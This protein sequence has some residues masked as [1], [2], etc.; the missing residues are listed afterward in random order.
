[1]SHVIEDQAERLLALDPT[2]SF[3]VQAPAG[4]GKT[5]LL[6]QRYL[7]LLA[8]V[9]RPEEILAV[10]FTKKAANEM[11][12][13]V[14]AALRH[15]K[16]ENEPD[17]AHKKQ[18]WKLARAVLKQD[19]LNHW[20]V[21]HNP[22]Q[23]R[24]QTI[25]SFCSYLTKHLPLLSQFGATPEIAP[26]ARSLYQEAVH[27]ILSHLDQDHPWSSAIMDVLAHLDNDMDKLA[28]LLIDLLAKRDQWLPYL[29]L[30]HSDRE[31]LETQLKSVI[32][33]LINKAKKTL[34]AEQL[35][36]LYA[37]ARYAGSQ[38]KLI[39]NTNPIA[40]CD[41]DDP[42]WEGIATLLLTKEGEFRKTWTIKQGFPS[43]SSASNA[44]DKAAFNHY[45]ACIKSLCEN[46]ADIPQFKENL[47]ELLH[48]PNS[49]YDDAQWDI[50]QS[51]L[52]LLKVSVA[53]LHVIFQR[54]RQ[55]DFIENSQAALHALGDQDNPTDLAL[56][57]DYQIKH[58]LID[59]FQDTSFSQFNLIEKLI[60]GWE[61]HDGKTLFIVG[62]PMQSIYR[63]RE[64]EVGLFIRAQTIGIGQLTLK[65]ITLSVSF[66]STREIIE[67]N[68]SNY[69]LL[70]PSSNDIATGAVSFSKS[71]PCDHKQN[72]KTSFV[73]ITG[74]R[75]ETEVNQG[76]YVVNE[77]KRLLQSYQDDTIAILVRSRQHLLDITPTLKQA[78]V[79][80]QAVEI[81]SL[82]HKPVI[83][84]LISLT[85]A[86]H[87]PEDRIAW[88]AILRAPWCGL[89]LSDLYEIANKQPHIS[90]LECMQDASIIATLSQDGVKRV[91][92]ILPILLDKIANR[93]RYPFRFW[94]ESTW[95]LLGGPAN[96]DNL[97]DMNDVS[98][99]LDLI[100][101]LES[102]SDYIDFESLESIL[103]DLYATR[104]DNHARVQLMTI[105]AAKGLEFDTVII[106][107]LERSGKR[108][109]RSMLSWM[110]WPIN[111]SHALFI[112]PIHAIG[113][114]PDTLYEF[115]RRQQSKKLD[116]EMDR[117]LY[118]ATTRAKK[119]LSL[120]FTLKQFDED[121]KPPQASFL[122]AFW[123]AWQNNLNDYMS[124]NQD[125]G[126]RDQP[127]KLTMLKR[128]ATDW[129]N[130]VRE[131]SIYTIASN[132]DTSTYAYHSQTKRE[133]GILVHR[134]LQELANRGT[135]W[136]KNQ[137]KIQ[138]EQYVLGLLKNR[139]LPFNEIDYATQSSILAV[140]N[141]LNDEM[142]NWI[143]QPHQEAK[144]EFAI[145]TNLHG[146]IT[147]HV[148]DITFIDGNIRWIIDYKTTILSHDDKEA[149]FE[150]ELQKHQSTLN[151][152][153][154][155]LSLLDNREIKIGLYFPSIPAWLDV[156]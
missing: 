26:N 13:R 50:L 24:I 76:I 143:L 121:Y 5:E 46:L 144:S 47:A 44:T 81:E 56:A 35:A 67:W 6:I 31:K 147:N 42:D 154:K 118:V 72:G 77:V 130:P 134:L 61:N 122:A 106:P 142:G 25:D 149:F 145:T 146:K 128:M 99:Y 84:D 28:T 120:Y 79:P 101:T 137:T 90:I 94:L 60:C 103:T 93:A 78:N 41:K 59:E 112:S 109:D 11:R 19:A 105:H 64:A 113:S 155:A 16:E 135:A 65:P 153:A 52:F 150:N 20:D 69:H 114:E 55:I 138:H 115:I 91:K 32:N 63:F 57:L 124:M 87:H 14:V 110:E 97:D 36:E 1:M 129:K 116:Y 48:L 107:H 98:T 62:D 58:L 85:R 40:C 95:L 70:F 132:I 83:Q 73:N 54:R 140:N 18:T 125:A 86:L 51:L 22:N 38:L 127:E 141:T 88:L 29:H 3:I 74:L 27:E 82:Y 4:S 34:P 133:I 7:T 71:S 39:D 152:Y 80:F 151:R 100:T 49:T 15:A 96:I 30:D 89:T 37:L 9:K 10:T 21:I 75:S 12:I 108:D 23:L 33:Y 43:A 66:R 102:K 136:W 92:R 148:I 123:P 131:A 2:Q 68:N 119:R 104:H 53:Q 45:K 139:L 17:S 126:E 111:E 117:L 8:T 156:K